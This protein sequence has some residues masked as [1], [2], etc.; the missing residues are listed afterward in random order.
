MRLGRLRDLVLLLA[1][2]AYSAGYATPG[3]AVLFLLALVEVLTRSWRWIPTA[4]DAPLLA[5]ALAAV[6]SALA[7]QWRGVSLML[8]L[9]FGLTAV[10]S[11]RSV[12]V[13]AHGGADDIVSLLRIWVAGGAA[14]ALWGLARSGAAGWAA[15]TTPGVGENGLGMTLAVALTLTVALAVTGLLRGRWTAGALTAVLLAGLILTRSRGGWLGAAVGVTLAILLGAPR[16][17]RLRLL[18][19]TAVLTVAGLT[20]LARWP[21]LG[22]DI[23]SLVRPEAEAN[24]SRLLIW[25]AIPRM[26]ADHPLLGTGYGTFVQ[27]YPRYRLPEATELYPPFAHN[28]WL[29]FA[30]ETG[31]VGLAA[32]LALCVVGLRAAWQWVQSSPPQSEGRGAAVA[33]FA[34]LLVLL[35][36]QMF[37]GS[38]MSV[39]LGFGFLALLI[40]GPVGI[41]AAET[42]LYRPGDARP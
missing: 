42:P 11:V 37:D 41:R 1:V 35:T 31:L 10:V 34:A 30:V 12:A 28:L 23:R 27:A 20:L 22:G 8:A 19:W 38:I 40:L 14:A 32:L 24:R 4:I 9:L 15:A 13:Y 26:V 25:R 3:L 36:T 29:N 2:A 39:H 6:A 5:L 16:P 18:L 33:V 21:A 17:A 7:S